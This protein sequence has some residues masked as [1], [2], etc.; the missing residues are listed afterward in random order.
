MAALLRSI[1]RF[2][3]RLAAALILLIAAKLAA[4][5]V[6]L[7]L[8]RIVDQLG[9]PERLPLLPVALLLAYA[10]LRF[11]TT[12]FAEIRD[13]V[14]SRVTQRTVADFTVR[15]FAHLHRL[16]ARFHVL[17]RTGALT[18]DVER[19]T[20]GIGFLLGVALFTIVPTLVEIAVI[21]GVM[22]WN[23]SLWF[24]GVISITFLCY[25]AF[26]VVFTQK[27][28]LHQRALNELDSSANSRLV[29]SLINHETVKYFTNER[30]EERRLRELMREWT[31]VGQRNQRALS[32]LHVGQSAIIACGVAAVMLFAGQQV[33]R[34]SMTVGDL[35][36]INAYVI[37]LCLPLNTLG[38]VFRQTKDA[39]VN[40]EKLFALL[41]RRP[42]ID[43]A[44][45]RVTNPGWTASRGEV[46]F[47]HVDF[48]YEP[49]RRILHDVSFRIAPGATVAIVGGSG[50]GKS[51]LARLLFRFYDVDN[52]RITIDGNDIREVAPQSVRR[53]IG[54]VP[55]DTVLFND[56]VEYNIAYGR[57]DAPHEEIVNAARAAHIHD[58]IMSLPE[59]YQTP[60][61]ERGLKLSGGE[62]QRLAVARAI[63]KDPPILV[64][65]EA[66]S[67][68][69]STSERAIQAE[70]E[71]L[72]RTRTALVI[73]HRLSTVVHADEI[74]VLDRGHIVERGNH[75]ELLSH[76]GAYAQMWQVQRQR[77]AHDRGAREANSRVM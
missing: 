14:F 64:F 38:F 62:K 31:R 6:P 22:V 11:S 32:M 10:L 66:T 3:G 17:R 25:T 37:Q 53:A 75:T 29:D 67:A 60:V 7:A 9:H 76:N 48:G 18:R 20:S 39:L 46:R 52:G 70:L 16:G 47:D 63:L 4:V 56:T 41:Q 26:T 19:G 72:A 51:T 43:D 30:F 44:T 21:L 23:Y 68:L 40:C 45:T 12:L 2:R 77:R 33:V 42:D 36:L 50:S 59:Q 57:I 49:A 74:L 24:A 58:F 1:W 5:A 73:A 8:K 55:Q 27:R 35:V 28:A 61:G 69:D 54:I 71:R 34:G 13:L 65:D 15:L